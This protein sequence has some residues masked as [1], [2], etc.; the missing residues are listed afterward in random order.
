MS[1]VGK[2]RLEAS[3]IFN[4]GA[5]KGFFNKIKM[6]DGS[7]INITSWQQLEGLCKSPNFHQSSLF[8]FVK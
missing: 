1:V 4:K 7:E 6:P 5:A 3:G 2:G 8:D